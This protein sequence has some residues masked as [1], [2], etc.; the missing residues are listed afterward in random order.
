M[1][2]Q[3][4]GPVAVQRIAG[5]LNPPDRPSPAELCRAAQAQDSSSRHALNQQES[6]FTRAD[7]SER[8]RPAMRRQRRAMAGPFAGRPATKWPAEG[9]RCFRGQRES[10]PARRQSK[11]ARP[12]PWQLWPDSASAASPGSPQPSSQLMSCHCTSSPPARCGP[13]SAPGPSAKHST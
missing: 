13:P 5:P 9:L 6:G 2:G 10:L 12:S 4:V 1:V 11:S 8:G 7:G 3:G